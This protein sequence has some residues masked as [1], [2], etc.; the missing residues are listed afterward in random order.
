MLGHPVDL[1]FTDP[2]TEQQVEWLATTPVPL[3]S[4]D[5]LRLDVRPWASRVHQVAANARSSRPPGVPC[6]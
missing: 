5:F 4:V 3:R 2:L 6:R 1:V